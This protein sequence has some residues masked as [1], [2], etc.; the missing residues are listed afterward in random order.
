MVPRTLALLLV[1]LVWPITG[2]TV[3]ESENIRSNLCR[4]LRG[5]FKWNGSSQIQNV[6]I[7]LSDIRVDTNN[8][9]LALGKGQYTTN[10]R[11]TDIDV[12]W[13]IDP[14]SGRFEMW[15]SNPTRPGF[16]TEGSHVGSISGDLKSVTAIWTT[17]G[18]GEQGTLVL[19][20]NSYDLV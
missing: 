16:V 2:W 18:T 11:V 14:K 7:S 9:V 4:Q 1:V 3:S 5:S 19:T 10:S 15:E 13:L 20:C 12:K 8:D 17:R 6:S